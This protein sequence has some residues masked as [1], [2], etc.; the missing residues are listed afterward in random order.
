MP[1]SPHW[2][3]AH[4]DWIRARLAQRMR[5][6]H[7]AT[8]EDQEDL[9]QEVMIRM[10]AQPA[11]PLPQAYLGRAMSWVIAEYVAKSQ[12]RAPARLPEDWADPTAARALNCVEWRAD[13]DAALA[14]LPEPHQLAF[15]L[16]MVGYGDAEIGQI[17]GW[18][19]VR[20]R[21]M[22]QRFRRAA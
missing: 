5:T 18:S 8:A 10:L 13:L 11:P 19:A 14:T 20:V 1:S 3:E 9:V 16:R 22:R 15:L 12:R 2:V 17:M 6:I 7:T 21:K 4:R